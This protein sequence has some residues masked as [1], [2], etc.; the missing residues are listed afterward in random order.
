MLFSC[1][2]LVVGFNLSA[3]FQMNLNKVA[4]LQQDLN[5]SCHMGNSKFSCRSIENQHHTDLERFLNFIG[6]DTK[7]W[8]WAKSTRYLRQF[9]ETSNSNSNSNFK[10]NFMYNCTPHF[11]SDWK[12]NHTVSVFLERDRLSRGRSW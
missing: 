6:I 9:S 3:I 4:G 12:I 2:S 8:N 5:L 11:L 7:I 1:V 10:S